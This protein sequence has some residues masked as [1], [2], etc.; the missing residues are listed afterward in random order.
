M[1]KQR[2]IVGI[3]GASGVIYGIRLLEV[4]RDVPGIE[5]HLVMSKA[6][7]LT[8]GYELEMSVKEVEAMADEVHKN[9][10]IGATIA[11]G[12]FR[13]MGMAVVPCSIKTL[14]GIVNAYDDTLLIRA[15]D[16]VLKE[17]RRLVVPRETPLNRN[18]LDLMVR[19]V[20]SGG[21]L[22]PP[23]PAYYHRPKT[24]DDIINHTVGKVLDMFGIEHQM[25][26]RW[27]GQPPK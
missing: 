18:H 21:I 13:T 2:L 4:L 5:T 27:S 3:T 19:L 22:V 26:E 25:F 23:M 9:T 14:S 10:N 12:S 1:D 20:D 15:A 17:Q 8:I 24:L 6:A 11:S 7:K 16:V